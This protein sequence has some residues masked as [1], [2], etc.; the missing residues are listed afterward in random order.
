MNAR[1]WCES[2]NTCQSNAD[3]RAWWFDQIV[4]HCGVSMID[5]PVGRG[6]LELL[7]ADAADYSSLRRGPCAHGTMWTNLRNALAARKKDMKRT[8]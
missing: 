2:S 8:K 5:L 6:K 1:P 7:Y 4:R 3:Y